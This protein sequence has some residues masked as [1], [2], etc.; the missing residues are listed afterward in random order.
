MGTS[1]LDPSSNDEE[2]GIVG[3]PVDF[4]T[5]AD[6]PSCYANN[7]LVQHSDY[8]FTVSFFEMRPPVL[9]GSPEQN[10]EKLKGMEA[11][12]AECVARIVVVPER[13]QDFIVALQTSLDKYMAHK[14]EENHDSG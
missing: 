5:P 4:H 7:I 10:L 8:E 12:Q 6:F 14:A 1:T 13:V 2:K 3:V 11:I 9:L